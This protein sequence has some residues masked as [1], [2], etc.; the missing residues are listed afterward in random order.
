[1]QSLD[2]D[3]KLTPKR[4]IYKILRRRIFVGLKRIVLFPN[5][6]NY[7]SPTLTFLLPD[8]LSRKSYLNIL[9]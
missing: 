2:T 3:I 4:G 8:S 5:I 1:M 6:D 7:F 9:S